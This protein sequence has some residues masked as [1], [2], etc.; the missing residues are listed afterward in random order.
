VKLSRL[1]DASVRV[2]PCDLLDVDGEGRI[3][4]DRTLR[5]ALIFAFATGDAG[6]V[7]ERAV[8]NVRLP[9]SAWQPRDFEDDVFVNDLIERCLALAPVG[10]RAPSN[11][12]LVRKILL[13]P[14]RDIRAARFRQDIVRELSESRE[15][16][17]RAEEL[18]DRLGLLRSLLAKSGAVRHD[19]HERRLSVLRSIRDIVALASS[20]FDDA[21]S[22][23][24]RI[25]AWAKATMA[26]PAYLELVDLLAYEDGTAEMD[27]RIRLGIDGKI[28]TFEV[29]AHR[30]APNRFRRSFL[31]RFF[32][33]VW[34]LLRGARFDA[35]ELLS[36]LTF[37][38]FEGLVPILPAL[39][40]L[41]AGLELYL[42]G[43]ALCDR[44]LAAGLPVCLPSLSEGGGHA[45]LSLWNPL[46][47]SEG[48][49]VV[50]CDLPTTGPG[51]RVIVTG[52][53]SGGKT[54]LLQAIALTQMLAQAG[55]FVPAASATLPWSSG[56]FVSLLEH[57]RAD[58]SEGKL[59]TELLRIRRLFENLSAGSVVILDELCAGTN[60]DEGEEIFRLVV[61]LLAE[62]GP[63]AFITT[64]FL[65]FAARLE[66]EKHPG[67]VF[68][69]VELDANEDP[70]FQFVPGVASTSLAH[71]TAL[72]L[73]VTEEALRAAMKRSR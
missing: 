42:S 62:L 39:F 60:P 27:V 68:L 66:A 23:L 50:P 28:R 57:A 38:V 43:L 2:L 3:D 14:P 19:A 45:A 8:E 17:A 65:R 53:N 16:R 55:L 7:L 18:L 24:G 11:I 35:H 51:S 67:L 13:A 64:H 56:L 15:R 58:Q 32:T 36:R 40:S 63:T 25:D 46:L 9:A 5:E 59:G 41:A 47:L 73:G 31:V 34:L 70:T 21:T 69:K 4:E 49:R 33:R 48:T 61:K 26:E 29:L 6:D 37:G 71:R 54:R 30:E 22:G 44:A 20:G 1:P 72:R 10:R 12:A 52:P